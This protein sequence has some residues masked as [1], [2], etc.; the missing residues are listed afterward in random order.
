MLTVVQP[1][2]AGEAQLQPRLYGILISLDVCEKLF[3]SIKNVRQ[4]EK[5][6][7]KG[8]NSYIEQGVGA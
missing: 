5:L 6:D 4:T 1:F 2:Y 7:L 8:I 3:N